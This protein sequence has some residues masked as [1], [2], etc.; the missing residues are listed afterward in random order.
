MLSLSGLD[1]AARVN[2][3]N[4]AALLSIH[5]DACACIL[6]NSHAHG[7]V[8]PSIWATCDSPGL[9]LEGDVDASDPASRAGN[10]RKDA[11]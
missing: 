4:D 5:A 1:L 11:G 6:C 10:S 3:I 7:G 2:S 8:I 9:P